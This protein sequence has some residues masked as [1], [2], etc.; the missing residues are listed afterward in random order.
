MQRFILALATTGIA[1]TLAPPRAL[2]WPSEYNVSVSGRCITNDGTPIPHARVEVRDD[3]WMPHDADI[4]GPIAVDASDNDICATGLSGADGS[5]A[6]SGTCGDFA[7]FEA[8]SKPDL[9]VRCSLEGPAGRIFQPSAPWTLYNATSAQRD[10]SDD[11]YDVGDVK[12]ESGAGKTFIS[13]NKTVQTIES[14]LGISL[15]PIWTMYPGGRE[16]VIENTGQTYW[17]SYAAYI[18]MAIAVGQEGDTLAHEYGHMLHFQA[19][20]ADRSSF[21]AFLNTFRAGVESYM[22]LTGEGHTFETISNPVVAFSEGWAEF[23][24]TVVYGTGAP[25]CT[26][27]KEIG[28]TEADKIKV[29]G[30]IA[31]RLRRL[32]ENWGLIDIWN[33]ERTSKATNYDQFIDEFRRIHPDADAV[34]L[35]TVATPTTPPDTGTSAPPDTDADAGDSLDPDADADAGAATDVDA[36]TTVVTPT[37]EEPLP[38]VVTPAEPARSGTQAPAAHQNVQSPETGCAI[39]QSPAHSLAVWFLI[40]AAVLAVFRRRR[41]IAAVRC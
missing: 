20:I 19:L 23:I 11:P 31:C 35:G 2:A 33:A 24:Q 7:L 39:T 27:W 15:Y 37:P 28:A 6:L 41:S 40:A 22:S 18:F 5:F 25:D 1:A 30:N 26:T 34:A 8:M 21:L 16:V 9:Y 14:H 38:P 29:E 12:I 10:N 32:Y 3:D 13:L 36:G 4:V 17:G